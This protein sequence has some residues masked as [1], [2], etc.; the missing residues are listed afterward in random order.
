MGSTLP[1]AGRAS[2]QTDWSTNTYAEQVG[3]NWIVQSLSRCRHAENAY[4]TSNYAEQ[5]VENGHL[6]R[7]NS[8]TSQWY[9]PQKSALS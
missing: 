8:S 4:A 5:R 9:R 1:V 7:P 3:E 6:F 2:A